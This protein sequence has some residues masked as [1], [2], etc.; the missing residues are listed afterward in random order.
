MTSKN[1][2]SSNCILQLNKKIK[3]YI[4]NFIL[5]LKASRHMILVCLISTFIWGFIAH[6]Y[7]F[8]HSSFSHDS[9][10][11]FNA[12]AFGNDW[13]ISLGRVF[14]PMYRFLVRDSITLP[15]LI[16][17]LSLFYIGIAVFL[18][19]KIFN[20]RSKLLTALISGVFTVNITVI[21]SAAT[22]IND[23]DCNML[24]LALAVLAVWLWKKY[25]KGFILGMVPICL[26]VGLYQS[27][28]SISITL[29]ILYLIV[30]LLNEKNFGDVLKKG[31]TGICMLIGGGILYFV[32]MK[33]IC[34]ITDNTLVTGSYNSMDT[35]LSMSIPDI[36]RTTIAGYKQAC[37]KI[38]VVT[39]VYPKKLIMVIR[40]IAIGI[41]GIVTLIS[42]FQKKIK[43]K[44]KI[45]ALVLILL[46]PI[47][48]NIVFTLTGGI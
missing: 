18:T 37:Y 17:I 10:N 43:I 45:L 20:I 19:V 23:L 21:A 13:K 33:V 42:I 32:S 40:M 24:A 38:L 48:M 11:E 15:W 29:I 30:Q 25:G 3:D 1:C 35:I 12:V 26:S 31:I 28:I 9:L 41:P 8:L 39:S 27:Y 47:G 6:S 14:V 5:S 22:Y 44:E 7:M 2:T 4:N 46:V 36:I 34:F 16:G